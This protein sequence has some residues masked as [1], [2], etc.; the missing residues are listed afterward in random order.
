MITYRMN[1]LTQNVYTELRLT[2]ALRDI[3]ET[4]NYLYYIIRPFLAML[5]IN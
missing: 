1:A 3:I 2:K 4:L 5:I